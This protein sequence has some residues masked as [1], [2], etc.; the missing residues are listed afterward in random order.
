MKAIINLFSISIFLLAVALIVAAGYYG[1]TYLWG[2]YTQLDFVIRAVLFIA[3]TAALLSAVIVSAGMRVAARLV[4]KSRLS[5]ARHE[6]FAH[7]IDLYQRYIES[8]N[9][10]NNSEQDVVLT[11]IARVE[12]DIMLLA[13]GASLNAHY[14]LKQAIESGEADYDRLTNLFGQLVKGFRR[15]LGHAYNYEELKFS[16]L[17]ASNPNEQT[18]PQETG[19][20]SLAPDNR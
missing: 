3:I 8:A 14:E 17:L 1:I 4:A 19:P 18:R 20:N 12:S 11:E 10:I 5:E 9:A 15:D 7:A 16:D 13:G 2:M 6:V